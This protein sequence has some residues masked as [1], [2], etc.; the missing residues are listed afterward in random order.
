MVVQG[1]L[2]TVDDGLRIFVTSCAQTRF[3]HLVGRLL[4]EISVG[5]LY[6]G[7]PAQF[8]IIV[9][10]I[11]RPRSN[12]VIEFVRDTCRQLFSIFFFA[13]NPSTTVCNH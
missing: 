4:T 2:C 7:V 8:I 12:P 3:G 11:Y 10:T 6:S 9:Y 13:G 5:D 1:Q